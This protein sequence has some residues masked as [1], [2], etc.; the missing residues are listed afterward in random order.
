MKRSLFAELRRRNVFKAGAS[1]LALG[2]VVGQI[3][4]ILVPALNLGSTRR[5]STAT[6]ALARS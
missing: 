3:T 5:S 2:W 4:A 1:C 6:P